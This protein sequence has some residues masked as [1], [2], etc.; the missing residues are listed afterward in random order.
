MFK[1]AMEI[2]LP[3]LPD[4]FNWCRT[5]TIMHSHGH[6]LLDELADCADNAYING[7]HRGI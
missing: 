2:W 4:I 6:H 7:T 5:F 3:D 1:R